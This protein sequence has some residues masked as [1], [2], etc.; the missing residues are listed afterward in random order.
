MRSSSFLNSFHSAAGE[1]EATAAKLVLEGRADGVVTSDGDA[2]LYGARV[3]YRN[4]TVG[5]ETCE[6]YDMSR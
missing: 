2:F 3:V 1:A 6:K 4:L 5:Q